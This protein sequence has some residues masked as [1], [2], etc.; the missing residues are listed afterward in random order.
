MGGRG[1]PSS[2][3]KPDMLMQ[4]IPPGQECLSSLEDLGLYHHKGLLLLGL[5]REKTERDIVYLLSN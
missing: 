2:D 1:W 3:G 4:E 5:S